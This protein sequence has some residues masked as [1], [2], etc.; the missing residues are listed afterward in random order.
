MR[1]ERTH[2]IVAAL[3]ARSPAF[4]QGISRF[5]LDVARVD[6][7]LNATLA[8]RVDT[9]NDLALTSRAHAPELQE[10]RKSGHPDES[11]DVC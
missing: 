10:Q 8:N 7:D 9:A 6:S 11:L 2:S 1:H 4:P 5:P 3:F